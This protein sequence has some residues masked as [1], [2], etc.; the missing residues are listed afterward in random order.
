LPKNKGELAMIVEYHRPE[1]LQAAIDLL[2][3]KNPP[4]YPLGGGTHLSH[5]Q[6]EPIAVVDLRKL[7]LSK[8]ERI[9]T[10]LR[11]GAAATLQEIID[12]VEVPQA[13]KESVRFETNY[14]LRQS[15]TAAGAL[16]SGDGKSP[17]IS[18]LLALNASMVV[19]PGDREE[20]LEGWLVRRGDEQK[21]MLITALVI[22]LDVILKY[23]FVGRSPL[24]IPMVSVAVGKWSTGRKR[25][26]IGGFGLSPMLMIDGT[27]MAGLESGIKNACSHSPNNINSKYIQQ[28][29]KTLALRLLEK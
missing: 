29:A 13:V 5:Y 12:S 18:A 25:I 23:D 6:G 15:A 14:N 17:F 20:M 1:T 16:V 9:E 4:T 28:T 10:S 22:P 3:R 27:E 7:G 11:I 21:N 2:S 19:Q 24:D 26:V 8:I